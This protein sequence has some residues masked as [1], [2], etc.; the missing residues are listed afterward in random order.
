LLGISLRTADV[1][2]FVVDVAPSSNPGD[3]VVSVLAEERAP[4]EGEVWGFE[5]LGADFGTFHTY[6]CHGLETEFMD[7]L[8]VRF[9]ERG[10]IEDWT[11]AAAASEWINRDEVGAEPVPWYPWRIDGYRLET[12]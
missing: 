12:V 8:G 9:N 3:G 2:D 6:L 1:G 10:L 4:I 5:V 11:G 7:V